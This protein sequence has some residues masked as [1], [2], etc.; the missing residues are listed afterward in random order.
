M[1]YNYFNCY[2]TPYLKRLGVAQE[3]ICYTWVVIFKGFLMKLYFKSNF[4]DIALIERAE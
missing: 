3:P 2:V 1:L 4:I